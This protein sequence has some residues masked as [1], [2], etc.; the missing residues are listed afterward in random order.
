MRPP[1]VWPVLVSFV[2]ALALLVTLNVAGAIPVVL[3]VGSHRFEA[4]ILTLPGLSYAASLSVV[5]LTAVSLVG[6][7]LSRTPIT[8]R[9]ALGPSRATTATL[10][11]ATVGLVAT[12]VAFSLALEISGYKDTGVLTKIT[13]ALSR[14]SLPAF[15]LALVCLALGPAVGEELYFRGFVQ[16]RLAARWGPAP[17]IAV[18]SVLFGV[19][20][21]DLKQG[22]F[23]ILAG[24]LLGWLAHAARSTRASVVAHC[25]NNAASLCLTRLGADP[26][27]AG[28]RGIVLAVALGAAALAIA[29]AAARLRAADRR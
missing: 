2:L 4:F 27:K 6:A 9:L 17:A 15:L 28:P 26:E 12:S 8:D 23:A 7:R 5:A 21:L 18:S 11:L 19:F 3:L 10:V 13:E 1:A 14:A 20:H 29:A 16:S 25:A 22:A 24:F